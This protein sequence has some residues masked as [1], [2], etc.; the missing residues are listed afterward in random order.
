[1]KLLFLKSLNFKL[2]SERIN[3]HALFSFKKIKQ[4]YAVRMLV[5]TL[6]DI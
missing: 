3:T 4:S 2:S 1:M 6:E 5:E